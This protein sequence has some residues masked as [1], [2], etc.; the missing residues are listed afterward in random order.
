MDVSPRLLQHLVTIAVDLLR[1]CAW[2]VLLLVIFAPVERLWPLHRQKLFRKNF[3]SD[4]V[5]YFLSGFAPK[6]L[7]ILP[8]SLVAAGVHRLAAGGLYP[9]V[10]AMPAGIRF[11]AATGVGEIGFYWGHRWSHEIPLLWRFHSLHHS[12]EEIDW[13][14]SSR[15]HPIDMVFTRLCGLV[16]MYL[17]GLAQPMGNSVDLVPVLVTLA[18]TVWGFFIHANV[19]WRFGWL[20]RIV[21]SPHFH[22]WH[23][24][25][26]GPECINKNYAPMLPWVDQMFGTL[27]LPKRAWPLKY[28]TD[29]QLAPSVAGQLLEPLAPRASTY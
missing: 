29:T 8:L 26:D 14:V 4:L 11:L 7:L 2:L 22:H 13:L 12:A 27:Y 3:G 18:G 9:W 19:N 28:G 21:S 5:Y 6:L 10:A 1:L 23:H 15:A 25:N 16:P 24:T 17:L 20:E